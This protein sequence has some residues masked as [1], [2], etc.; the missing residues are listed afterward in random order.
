MDMWIVSFRSED[1]VETVLYHSEAE[2]R[3]DAKAWVGPTEPDKPGQ[4]GWM[5]MD[6][7][8]SAF[9]KRVDRVKA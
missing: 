5:D 4:V 2:A 1:E 3:K 8:A 7:N 9:M 6:G